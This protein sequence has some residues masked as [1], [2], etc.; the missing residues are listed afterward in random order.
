MGYRSDVLIA[1]AFEN[2]EHRDEVWAIYCM[3]HPLRM[4]ALHHMQAH[5]DDIA[6]VQSALDAKKFRAQ[7]NRWVNKFCSFVNKE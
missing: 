7:F 6:H 4:F 3:D 1:V 5:V 2:S